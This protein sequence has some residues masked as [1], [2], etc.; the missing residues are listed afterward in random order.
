MIPQTLSSTILLRT[1]GCTAYMQHLSL[2]VQQGQVRLQAYSSSKDDNPPTLVY[3]V[4]GPYRRPVSA[5]VTSQTSEQVY[6]TRLFADLVS[7][8]TGICRG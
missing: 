2:L 1:C 4:L 5:K 6:Y 8:G 7:P 3:M